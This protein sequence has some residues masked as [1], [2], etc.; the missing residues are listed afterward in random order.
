M[1]AGA[2]V[3]SFYVGCAIAV[4]QIFLFLIARFYQRMTGERTRPG[5]FLVSAALLLAGDLLYVSQVPQLA[6]NTLA[7]V[8]LLAGGCVLVGSSYPLLRAMTG[9]G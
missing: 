5:L 1:I 3:L 7:D 6:G 9:Q 8:F 2:T 4:L